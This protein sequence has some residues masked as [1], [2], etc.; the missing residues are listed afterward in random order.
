MK[1]WARTSADDL[2]P[3]PSTCCSDTLDSYEF[4]PQLRESAR[5]LLCHVKA[6]IEAMALQWQ[7]ECNTILT[8]AA[9]PVPRKVRRTPA[10]NQARRCFQLQRC[11]CH[12]GD[13]RP[14]KWHHQLHQVVKGFKEDPFQKHHFV[15]GE[16]VLDLKNISRG[17]NHVFHLSHLGLRP[18]SMMLH[19]LDSDGCNLCARG[20]WVDAHDVAQD[21]DLDAAWSVE[22]HCVRAQAIM[23]LL[24]QECSCFGSNAL[25]SA[26]ILLLRQE[27]TCLPPPSWTLPL[28]ECSRPGT[29]AWEGGRGKE[30]YNQMGDFAIRWEFYNHGA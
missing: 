20:L 9:A 1:V 28:R 17:H 6:G 7:N 21:T 14:A 24:R 15:K 22:V 10:Q 23:L 13:S 26:R 16:V 12:D 27:C 8:V 25:A 3:V 5:K 18:P 29:N 11:S 4:N 19:Q 30:F 2:L